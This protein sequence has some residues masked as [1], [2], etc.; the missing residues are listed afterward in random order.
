MNY[1]M[2][3]KLHIIPGKADEAF[4]IQHIVN[5]NEKSFIKP[6]INMARTLLLTKHIEKLIPIVLKEKPDD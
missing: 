5:N 6:A 2:C 4:V 1:T 3:C